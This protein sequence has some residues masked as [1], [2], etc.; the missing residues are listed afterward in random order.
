MRIGG[1]KTTGGGDI[2]DSLY[3][4]GSCKRALK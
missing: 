1:K 4:Q 3:L 2:S